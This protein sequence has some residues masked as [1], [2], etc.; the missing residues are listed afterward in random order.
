MRLQTFNSEG[1]GGSFGPRNFESMLS[2]FSSVDLVIKSAA[3]E[4]FVSAMTAYCSPRLQVALLEF[5][6]HRTVSAGGRARGSHI[7]VSLHREGDVEISQ[8]ERAEGVRPGDIFL[9]DPARP[10]EIQ[11]G[12]MQTYSIYIPRTHLRDKIPNLDGVTGRALSSASGAGATFRALFEE[13]F[14]AAPI[15]SDTVADQIADA[16]PPLLG[17]MASS[18]AE[19]PFSASPT[20][21]K[22]MHRRR[23][24]QFATDHLPNTELSVETISQA[25]GLSVRYVHELF[26]DQQTTLMRWIWRERLDRCRRDLESPN[27]RHR[28]IGEI[29][30]GWGFNDLAHFSRTFSKTFG[31][32][33]RQFRRDALK[34]AGQSH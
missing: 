24:R 6:P 18:I 17:A 8:N 34:A 11:T 29:A 31:L 9:I 30:Y 10:F 20:D 12:S 16:F 27:L 23:I 22:L 19:A 7:L 1:E 3:S 28:T 26:A 2:T 15:L 14:T 5:S 13:V 32:S 4:P 21:L 33:P 25:V